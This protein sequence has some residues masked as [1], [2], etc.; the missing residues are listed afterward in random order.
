MERMELWVEKEK[1]TRLEGFCF[2]L[3]KEDGF[4]PTGQ[5]LKPSVRGV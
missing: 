5:F 2:F 4:Y 3:N 1:V